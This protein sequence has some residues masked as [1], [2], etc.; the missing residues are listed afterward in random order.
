MIQLYKPYIPKLPDLEKILYSG[1]LT[2][3]EYTK[4]FEE[5]LRV[6]FNTP[7]L[8][9]TSS[10]HMAISVVLTTL[11]L[12]AGDSI[13]SSPMACLASTQPYLSYGLN[14]EWADVDPETGTLDPKKLEKRI[15]NKTKVIVHNHFCGYPGYI[16]EI[17]DIGHKYGIPIIDDGIEGFGAEYHGMKIGNCGTDITIFALTAVRFCNC[18][19]GGIV[20]FKDKDL[21]KKSLL[22]RDF[23]IDRTRFRDERGEIND[24]DLVGYSAMMSNVNGYM[25][26]MQMQEIGTILKKHR[27]QAQKWRKFCEEQGKLIPLSRNNCNPNYWVYGILTDN[28]EDTIKQFREMGYYASGVH[29]RNDIYSIFGKQKMELPGVEEFYKRFVALP[30]GWWME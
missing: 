28:K 15:T 18:I 20:I 9:V 5:I 30:C 10:F 1:S 24:I 23:G 29:M 7:F 13:I 2:Y 6:Y 4:K 3:G 22:I 16:N 21:F 8:M 17:N 26:I 11:G 14:V 12:K 27:I 19:D 25:G